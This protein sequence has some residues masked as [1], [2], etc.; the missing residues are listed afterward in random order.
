MI[1]KAN[2]LN[3]L[4]EGFSSGKADYVGLVYSDGSV[5]F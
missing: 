5:K 4:N 2:I 1:N 3:I